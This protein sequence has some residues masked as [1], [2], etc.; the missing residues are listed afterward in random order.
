M[1]YDLLAPLLW[2][3]LLSFHTDRTVPRVPH[4]TEVEWDLM[5]GQQT[6]LTSVKPLKVPL[7]ICFLWDMLPSSN[8]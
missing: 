4:T 8:I 2:W 1:V 5:Y 6:Q 7:E 3:C